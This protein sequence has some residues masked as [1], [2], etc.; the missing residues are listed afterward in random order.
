MT[1]DAST[2]VSII[3]LI[4]IGWLHRWVAR[5]GAFLLVVSNLPVSLVHETT[6]YVISLLLGGRPSGVN[7]WPTVNDN[8]RWILGSVTFRPTVLSAFP[9]ALAPVLLLP[10]GLGELAEF[11]K[12][13]TLRFSGHP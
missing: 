10:L 12:N 7:L 13:R 4:F 8:G 6:H 5:K 9:S 2:V 3:P 1:V 11:G